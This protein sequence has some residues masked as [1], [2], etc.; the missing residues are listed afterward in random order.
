MSSIDNNQVVGRK[1][2]IQLN[3][4]VTSSTVNTAIHMQKKGPDI[5]QV[6]NLS[7]SKWLTDLEPDEQQ[8]RQLDA[9]HTEA[10]QLL[11]YG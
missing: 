1:H 6:K 11:G 3:N 7:P 4:K 10:E 8:Q 9:M 2:H 5:Q